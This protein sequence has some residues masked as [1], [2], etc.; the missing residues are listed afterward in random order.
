MSA[1]ITFQRKEDAS[2]AIQTING[3]TI[4]GRAIRYHFLHPTLVYISQV[5]HLEQPN[6]VHIL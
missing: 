3:T 2:K 6:I 5:L 4:E 1:Y